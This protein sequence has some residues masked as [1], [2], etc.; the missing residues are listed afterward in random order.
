MSYWMLLENKPCISNSAQ[1]FW[2]EINY[3]I[4]NK[5]INSLQRSSPKLHWSESNFEFH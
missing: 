1:R 5:F 2:F 4:E 3:K